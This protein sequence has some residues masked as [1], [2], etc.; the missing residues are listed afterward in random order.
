MGLNILGVLVFAQ[1][2]SQDAT[3]KETFQLRKHVEELRQ[4]EAQPRIHTDS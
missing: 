4:G 1:S 2:W 3:V